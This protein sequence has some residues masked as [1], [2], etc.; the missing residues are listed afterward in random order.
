MAE[1]HPLELRDRVVA[2][3][4]AGEG[5]YVTIAENFAVSMSSVRRWV[6]QNRREGHVRPRKKGGGNRSDI[7]LQQ[8][9]EIVAR[10]GDANA[11]EIT[12]EYNRGRRGKSR[13]HVSSIKR[14][15]RRAG[16]VVKKNEFGRW[17]SSDQT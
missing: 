13:R 9:E 15:L 10:L 6:A 5:G 8:L 11:G 3:Y 12:A 16:F 1:P 7:S 2:A 17:S 14:A 4:E